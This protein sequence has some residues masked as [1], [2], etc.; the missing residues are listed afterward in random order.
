LHNGHWATI[1][2]RLKDSRRRQTAALTEGGGETC[3]SRLCSHK[4]AR[5]QRLTDSLEIL[6]A[7]GELKW[8]SILIGKNGKLT[9]PQTRR[10]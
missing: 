9:R 5:L 8:L 1:N 2:S 7:I 4:I 10:E 3:E 6:S